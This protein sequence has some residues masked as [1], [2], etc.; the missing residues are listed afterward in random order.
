MVERR[1]K[2]KRRVRSGELEERRFSSVVH[3]GGPGRDVVSKVLGN[4]AGGHTMSRT[5]R[6]YFLLDAREGQP[7]VARSSLWLLGANSGRRRMILASSP[8]KA[9]QVVYLCSAWVTPC[10]AGI[11]QDR[12]DVG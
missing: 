5:A 1:V 3:V 11:L 6:K 12:P 9:F 7:M 4:V 8:L 10:R 2:H